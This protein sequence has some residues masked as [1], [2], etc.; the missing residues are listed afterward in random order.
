MRI[1]SARELDGAIAKAQ[2]VG[3][4]EIPVNL[5]DCAV[6]LR[7]LRPDEY[8]AVL[9]ECNDLD[10]ANFLY[11]YQK[12]H[13][14]RSIVEIN[15]RDLRGIDFVEVEEAGADGKSKQVKLELHDYLR[16]RVVD[17]WSKETLHVAYRKFG[18]AVMLAEKKSQEGIVFLLPEETGEEKFRRLLG[19]LKEVQ[20][21]VPESLVEKILEDADLM[22]KPTSKM[23]ENFAPE[24]APPAEQAPV[25]APPPQVTT[26]PAVQEVTV[27]RQPLNRQS[28]QLPPDPHQT[29][30]QAVANRTIA[31]PTTVPSAAPTP[32]PSP[33]SR[34]DRSREIAALEGEVELSPVARPAAELPTFLPGPDGAP[35]PVRGPTNTEVAELAKPQGKIHP[36]ALKIDQPPVSGINPRYRPPR[37]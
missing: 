26:A 37:R 29:F 11:A 28:V 19:E 18:E 9:Q 13:V 3:I 1:I 17:T 8:T 16:K 7:N 31:A 2:N 23:L 15:G 5:G 10:E 36:E 33:D 20:A 12:G 27:A 34:N 4:E 25:V 35:L 24:Q 21:E 30:Q 32:T 14:A 22:P 6:V